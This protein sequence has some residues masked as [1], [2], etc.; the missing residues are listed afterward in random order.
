MK[1]TLKERLLRYLQARP[2]VHVSSGELQ[3]LTVEKTTYTAQNA[4]RRLRELAE[5]GIIEVEYRKGHAFYCY[6]PPRTRQ[7][8]RI[9][10]VDGVAKEIIE[11]VTT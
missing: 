7:V 1:L 8:R 5:D 3:R 11:T 2:G 4:G 6:R 9:E 10:V